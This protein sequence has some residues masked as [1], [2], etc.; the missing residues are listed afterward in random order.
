MS[1]MSELKFRLAVCSEC[2]DDQ[3]AVYLVPTDINE[4]GEDRFV[5]PTHGS[6]EVHFVEGLL[7][8]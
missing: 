4:R 2:S 1:A 5:C 7:G 6:S 3:R 8:G